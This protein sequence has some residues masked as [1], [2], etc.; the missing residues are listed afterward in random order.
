[1][2]KPQSGTHSYTNDRHH[3]NFFIYN[4]SVQMTRH[5]LNKMTC[6]SI[7]NVT[8]HPTPHS[9]LDPPPNPGTPTAPKKPLHPSDPHSRDA[10]PIEPGVNC[11]KWRFV[12]FPQGFCYGRWNNWRK[13]MRYLIENRFAFSI[14]H[15]EEKQPTNNAS[16]VFPSQFALVLE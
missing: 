15:C 4:Y 7:G 9:P 14:S 12:V 13:F 6:T 1:M 10:D 16:A 5:G 2:E 8:C 11:C 3:H